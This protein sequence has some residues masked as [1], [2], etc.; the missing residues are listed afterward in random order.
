M[1]W[2]A[3]VA[4]RL[5]LELDVQHGGL[6]VRNSLQARSE[7]LHAKCPSELLFTKKPHE[8]RPAT[9]LSTLFIL[10]QNTHLSR[11]DIETLPNTCNALLDQPE[12]HRPFHLLFITSKSIASIFTP[13]PWPPWPAPRRLSDRCPV[14]TPQHPHHLQSSHPMQRHC[15]STLNNLPQT[16]QVAPC[17]LVER[18]RR[19]R[20]P[21]RGSMR[22]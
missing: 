10:E 17:R 9:A 12:P 11:S 15:G 21:R 1:T 7:K 13:T 5:R 16:P 8:T 19:W 4:A 2:N 22:R 3:R 14:H 18:R 6:E 20:W